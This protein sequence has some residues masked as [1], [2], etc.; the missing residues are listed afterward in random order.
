[1]DVSGTCKYQGKQSADCTALIK[2]LKASFSAAPLVLAAPSPSVACAAFR[3]AGTFGANFTCS[4][5][6]MTFRYAGGA[7]IKWLH[8]ADYCWQQSG[9]APP[10]LRPPPLPP[11]VAPLPLVLAPPSDCGVARTGL[12]RDPEA[13]AWASIQLSKLPWEGSWE[14]LWLSKQ[15][16]VQGST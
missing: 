15:F 10:T 16:C 2:S 11:A 12:C 7:R 8:L 4:K 13:Q 14:P 6:T 3:L 9:F 5:V 1:M